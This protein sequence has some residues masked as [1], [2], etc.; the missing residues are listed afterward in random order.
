MPVVK[1]RRLVSP[2]SSRVKDF[3]GRTSATRSPFATSSPS[4]MS[5][6]STRPSSRP[7][8]LAVSVRIPTVWRNSAPLTSISRGSTCSERFTSVIA[9]FDAAES[10]VAVASTRLERA[11]V[12]HPVRPPAQVLGRRF[13]DWTVYV[14]VHCRVEVALRMPAGKGRK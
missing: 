5:T 3:G 12:V 8:L 10:T 14:D 2:A 1:S 6:A 7:A 13:Y 4:S 11:E 9:S